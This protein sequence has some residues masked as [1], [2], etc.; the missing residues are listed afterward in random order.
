MKTAPTNKKVREILSAVNEGRI[1]PRPEFQRRLVWKI[2]DKNHFLDTVLNGYPF[3]EIYLADGDVDLDTG[4]GT[5]LLVDG[6]QRVNTLVQ[7][8]SGDNELKLKNIPPYKELSDNQKQSFLQYDVAVRDLG[9][10]TSDQ[11]VEIFRR[12]NATKYSLTDIEISNAIYRGEFKE[13]SEQ[14]SLHQFFEVHRVFNA[15][16][17]RRMGD[18]RFA[19]LLS[20]TVLGGYFNRDDE[21]ERYLDRYNDDFDEGKNL[22][23]NFEKIFQFLDECG[24]DKKSRVWRKAD[25]FTLIIETYRAII[26][27]KIDLQPSYVLEKIQSFYN[28]INSDTIDDSQLSGVYYKS[29]LQA[30]NDRNNRIRRGIIIGSL[31]C[32]DKPEEIM[33]KL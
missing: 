22:K 30:S 24:F 18:L 2:E 31:L 21:F 13:F 4:R 28:S 25:L 5:Q 20:V 16:D 12:L 1:E 10:L 19:L 3:P 11:I 32:D 33:K 7:Y 8:F 6:L 17:Y 29:A 23:E 27:D 15:P 14:L 26:Q 9:K